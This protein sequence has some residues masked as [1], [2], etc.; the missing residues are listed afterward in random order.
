MSMTWQCCVRRSTSAAT[1]AANIPSVEQADR[2]DTTE[3]RGS[4][5]H[6]PRATGRERLAGWCKKLDGLLY[7]FR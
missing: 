4:V 3:A 7:G 1:Q 6:T 2:R 5:S